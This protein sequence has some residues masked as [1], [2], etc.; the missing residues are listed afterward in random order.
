MQSFDNQFP[1]LFGKAGEEDA[2]RAEEGDTDEDGR[3]EDGFAG[4][5]GWIASVDA[6][7]ETIR[8]PWDVVW[9]MS[10]VEFLNLLCYR[11]DKGT[12]E[13]EVARK[14]KEAH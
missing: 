14:W 11:N 3:V 6:V 12:H 10:C 5:W 1:N 9:D 13:E 2:T 4:R 7:S 8:S